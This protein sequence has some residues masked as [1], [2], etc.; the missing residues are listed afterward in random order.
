MQT[1]KLSDS[2]KTASRLLRQ[3]KRQKTKNLQ[4][5]RE[6]AVSEARTAGKKATKS[7]ADSIVK[8]TRAAKTAVKAGKAPSR[9]T[10]FSSFLR[11]AEA[12]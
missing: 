12:S 5:S 4:S 1:A 2:P 8:S 11:I 10:S 3:K 7:F 9:M 6:K